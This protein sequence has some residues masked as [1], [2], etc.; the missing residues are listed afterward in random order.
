MLS[1]PW[2]GS[3]RRLHVFN[4]ESGT[5]LSPVQTSFSIPYN[6]KGSSFRVLSEPCAHAPSPDELSTAPFHPDPSQ[7]IIALNFG[8]VQWFVVNA[9]KLLEL[10]RE[11]EGKDVRWGKWETGLT[12]VPIGIVFSWDCAWVSGCRLFCVV[13]GG[14]DGQRSYL[15]V[16][17]LSHAGRAK[18]LDVLDWVGAGKS[19]PRQWSPSLDGYELPWDRYAFFSAALT[20]A[21]DSVVFGFVS[22]AFPH[23]NK[24]FLFAVLSRAG[25]QSRALETERSTCGVFESAMRMGLATES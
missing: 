9:E 25:T 6:R 8:E 16:L 14:T 23:L 21:H 12:G 2:K 20:V 3:P 19:G 13:L 22:G 7:R 10:A 17:D 4:T 1:D 11:H 18:E 15:R 5:T 24:V